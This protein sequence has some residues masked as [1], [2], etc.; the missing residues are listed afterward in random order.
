MPPLPAIPNLIKAEIAGTNNGGHQW[1]NVMHFIYT[2]PPPGMTDC[3]NFANAIRAQFN[4]AFLSNMA[5]QASTETVTVTDLSSD[6]GAKAVSAFSSPGTST[7]DKLPA[8]CCTL[9]TFTSP[10]LYRGGHPRIY[11]PTG[12]DENLQ[13]MATWNSAY[14]AAM[15]TAFS[16]FM[17][18]VVPTTSGATTITAP[19]TPCYRGHG[20]PY[21]PGTN[22]RIS[23]IVINLAG[24]FFKIAAELASQRR[25]IGRK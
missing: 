22:I 24:A 13:D 6:M 23:P 25:R 17:L 2:G 19:A 18:N 4:L 16:N 7:A 3:Q 21:I 10:L 20:G 8:N 12:M 5:P 11:L 9:V 15:T 14:I 1:A